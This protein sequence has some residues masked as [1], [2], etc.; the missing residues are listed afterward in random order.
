[1]RKLDF[2][3]IAP[4]LS[5]FKAGANKTNFGGF[6][7]LIYILILLLLAIIYIFDYSSKEKYSFEY[8]LFQNDTKTL[9]NQEILDA[10]I[11]HNYDFTFHLSKDYR[12]NPKDL[13]ENDNF[14][15]INPNKLGNL[16]KSGKNYDPNDGFTIINSNDECV[17]NQSQIITQQLID[18]LIVLYRCHGSDGKNCNINEKD[19]IKVDSYRLTLGYRGFSLDHQNA[20]PIQ[21]IPEGF[22]YRRDIEFLENTNIIYLN[23]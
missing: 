2:I 12:D 14:L 1:M 13:Y 17:M 7:F 18:P 4:R 21:L 15:L 11:N 6:L 23:W 10:T 9:K 19:K 3:S 8:N 16:K 22:E 5:I 20:E